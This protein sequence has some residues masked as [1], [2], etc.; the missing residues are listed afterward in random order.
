MPPLH[1]K[2]NDQNG[3]LS[4]QTYQHHQAHLDINVVV[5]PK[6]LKESKYPEYTCRYRQHNGKR[7]DIT[8]ILRTQQE[9]DEY[10]AQD[11]DEDDLGTRRLF[12]PGDPCIFIAP[13]SR[14]DLCSR[15]INGLD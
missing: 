9:V 10:K 2:F 5:Y 4:Q 15:F 6:E 14:Q 8:F 12:F 3:I 11:K 1:R 7:Q 13:S